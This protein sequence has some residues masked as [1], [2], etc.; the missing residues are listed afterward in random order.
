MKL[1]TDQSKKLTAN[2]LKQM[3]R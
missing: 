3:N 1:A 2:K